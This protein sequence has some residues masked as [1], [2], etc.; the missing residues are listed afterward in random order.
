MSCNRTSSARLLGVATLALLAACA[1]SGSA[2]GP[3]APLPAGSVLPDL[4]GIDQDGRPVRLKDLQGKPLLVFFYPK[5]GTPGC[6]KEACAI[7]DVWQRYETAGIRVVG[8]SHDTVADQAAFAREHGFK[9]PLVSDVEGRWGKAFGVP[10]HVWK[11][12][13]RISF[14]FGRKGLVA[15][16]YLDVDPGVHAT[17]V[18][19][20]AKG[21]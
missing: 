15:K 3:D 19:A 5:A 1:S 6:T 16:T 14:L 11:Y 10:L 8:V 12:Y 4:T 17:Q 9:F 2:K 7:R 21:L 13:S 18:L 20:D